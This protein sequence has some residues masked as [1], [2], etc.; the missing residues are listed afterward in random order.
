MADVRDGDGC[1]E[2]RSFFLREAW[3]G[4]AEVEG[5]APV[6]LQLC[7]VVMKFLLQAVLVKRYEITFYPKLSVELQQW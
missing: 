2:L 4:L 3:L 7:L 5:L 6:E 1:L